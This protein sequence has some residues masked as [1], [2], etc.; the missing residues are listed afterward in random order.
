MKIVAI[1]P[2]AGLSR[3]MGTPKLLL[4][5]Q[6]APVLAR[7]ISNLR[8]GGADDVMVVAPP[9]SQE[10]AREVATIARQSGARVVLLEAPT[11]D[12]RTTLI[13]GLEAMDHNPEVRG[14]LIAPADAVG[15]S[16]GLV[17]RVISRFREDLSKIVIPVNGTRRGHPLAIPL[18]WFAAIRDL[19]P[20]QGLNALVRS[21]ADQTV[22][23]QADDPRFADDLNTPEDY[24]RLLHAA[25]PEPC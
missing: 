11:P 13:R 16:S 15:M 20:D 10:G 22:E 5:L 4:D 8:D 12:M 14:V 7:V 1:V 18:G 21:R 6:G 25:R 3:R 17:R 23:V 2:A 19:P 9:S 24:Q